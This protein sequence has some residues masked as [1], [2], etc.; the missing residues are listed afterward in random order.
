KVDAP[1]RAGGQASVAPCHPRGLRARG[2]GDAEAHTDKRDDYGARQAC[3]AAKRS[4]STRA[5]PIR[6]IWSTWES[7]FGAGHRMHPVPARERTHCGALRVSTTK[8]FV[9]ATSRRAR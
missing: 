8:W 5:I 2:R 6:L 7:A 4:S 1:A 3:S 9:V